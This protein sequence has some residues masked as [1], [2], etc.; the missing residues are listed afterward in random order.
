MDLGALKKIDDYVYEIPQS[1]RPDMR[2]PARVFITDELL[3]EIKDDKSLDQLVNVATIPGIYKYALAM[4]D[5][6][7][8]YGF[9]VGGVAATE[10][11]NGLISP[12]GIGYDINCGVRLLRSNLT[13]KQI[14]PL[15]HELAH[16]LQ[17]DVPS[18]V[19]EGGEIRLSRSELDEVLEEGAAWVIEKRGLG[20]KE[21]L[22]H[23]ES[24]GRLEE[25]QAK[26]V[27]DK[28]KKRGKDQ[29]G[30]LGAGNHFLEVER[31]EQILHAEAAKQMG[32]LQDQ[33]VVMIHCGSR[34]LGHQNA[35]DYIA[36]M[37]RVMG[38]YG[39][40]LPDRELAGVPFDTI[41][42]RN[43][44]ASMCASA[45][46]AW[47]NRQAITARVRRS[48]AKVL[49]PK[50]DADLEIVYDV[51]HN[52]AKIENYT[53]QSASS[54]RKSVSLL[55]HRK[56]ATRAFPDQPVLIPGSMGTASYVL[57]GAQKSLEL[58]FG[59]TCHGAGR[60]MSRTRAKKE[61]RGDALK[62]ELEGRGIAV[63]AGSLSGLAEEAPQAYKNIDEVVQVVNSLGIARAVAR[64]VPIAVVKG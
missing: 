40:N 39:V 58:S 1:Y 21:D 59:T 62:R 52:I 57:V 5:I 55:V 34:G 7:Q 45:N 60:R 14:K 13:H 18:G 4:P 48:F 29:L 12:G 30:T 16:E 56:G 32:L 43:Y 26:L 54:Q 17:R 3:S 6:H 27:S 33:V 49:P 47:A 53:L 19:G 41:E 10:L 8:G 23:L 38:K 11:P 63:A 61:V 51:A 42:G 20:K 64:L 24:N 50:L 46:F 37:T 22:K 9:P 44:F 31:V 25:A 28:A 35:T 2:V 36:L 15:L